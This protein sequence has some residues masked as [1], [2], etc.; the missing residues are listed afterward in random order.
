MNLIKMNE[1]VPC[2]RLLSNDL[3]AAVASCDRAKKDPR[4]QGGIG[5]DLSENP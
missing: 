4:E 3:G 5:P 2:V 1:V